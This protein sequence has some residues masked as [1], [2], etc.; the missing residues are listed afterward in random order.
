[1]PFTPAINNQTG[2]IT[3]CARSFWTPRVV[4]TEWSSP[5]GKRLPDHSMRRASNY[6][7]GN[8]VEKGAPGV[9][10]ARERNQHHIDVQRRGVHQSA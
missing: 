7:D 4:D 10:V 3:E 2:F 6:P 8:L 1:M 5:A 9:R